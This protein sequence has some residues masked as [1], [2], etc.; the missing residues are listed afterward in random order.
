MLFEN[1]PWQSD[2]PIPPFQEF[3]LWAQRWARINRPTNNGRGAGP[4][5]LH[6]FL[7]YPFAFGLSILDKDPIGDKYYGKCR[8]V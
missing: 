3:V 1:L 6:Q 2:I 4:R 5:V 8:K 7:A